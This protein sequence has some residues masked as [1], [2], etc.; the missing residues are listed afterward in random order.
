MN[1]IL[2]GAPGAGK[3]TQGAL[4]SKSH[5]LHRISTG[6]LLRNA[7]RN[8]TRL[9]EE[10]RPYMEAGELVPDGII[11]GLI[12]EVLSEEAAAEGKPGGYIFDGFPRTLP[13]AEALDGILQDLGMRLDA[14]V[15]I[16]VPEDALV[17]RISGRR[18]CPACGA[19][20]NV[21]L[22]PPRQEGVCDACGSPLEQRSDDDADTVRR[23]LQVYRRDTE[24]LIDYYRKS[25][26]QV[27]TIDGSQPPD[28]VN[29]HVQE[30][31]AR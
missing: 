13:Q 9:G 12:R 6:D 4:L 7:V 19:V 22:D 25:P 29:H 24:P 2:L 8:R 10:A 11:L 31:L 28:V 27:I 21:Y 30:A 20:F 3:G 18:S 17:Q 15:V 1:L 26:T 23:R 16:D 5:G 14:V